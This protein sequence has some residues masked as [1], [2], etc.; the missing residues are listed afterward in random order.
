MKLQDIPQTERD[1][2]NKVCAKCGE[3][4]YIAKKFDMHF[5]W[6]DCPYDCE[7]DLEHLLANDR[8]IKEVSNYKGL[9]VSEA[10]KSN[11]SQT[12][13]GIGKI[14]N[15]TKVIFDAMQHIGH[16]ESEEQE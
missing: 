10:E 8:Q 2:R 13:H 14:R 12:E 5:D 9:A 1:R 6:L 3:R 4:K 7:N 15:V 11:D 16:E